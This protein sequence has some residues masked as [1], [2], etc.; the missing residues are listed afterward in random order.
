VYAVNWA[1]IVV[2]VTALAGCVD[3][4]AEDGPS[5]PSDLSGALVGWHDERAD[6]VA[7]LFDGEDLRPIAHGTLDA[8]GEVRATL[9]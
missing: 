3:G 9:P 4:S 5:V 1:L 7:E 6:L 2:M 8:A